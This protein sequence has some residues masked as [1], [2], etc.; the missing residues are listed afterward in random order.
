MIIGSG[1]NGSVYR[2]CRINDKS[3][4]CQ[5]VVKVQ[6]HNYQAKQE[7]KAYTALAGKRIAPKLHAAWVCKGKLYLVLDMVDICTLSK[8]K[9]DT[10]LKRL[11]RLG[12]L[13]VDTHEGNVMCDA[14]GN[15]V[16]IDF[17]W[18]VH[19]DDMSAIE[20]HPTRAG[21]F[22]RLKAIQ[23]RNVQESFDR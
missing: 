10:A 7:V 5:Y 19:K 3:E 21:T 8:K 15:T 13:H 18:A 6:P 14:R 9:V 1:A 4:E 11:Y 16:L 22:E 12:W 23:A 20:N 2:A 17:G